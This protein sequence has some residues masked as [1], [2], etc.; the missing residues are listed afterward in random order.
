MQKTCEC[1]KLH[2]Y[3]SLKKSFLSYT[4]S[5]IPAFCACSRK[6][7]SSPRSRTSKGCPG[8]TPGSEGNFLP[9]SISLANA[10][11]V[12]CNSESTAASLACVSGQDGGTSTA[13][14]TG[15]TAAEVAA[16]T[17]GAALAWEEAAI[18]GVVV[19]AAFTAATGVGVVVA[20]GVGVV[21]AAVGAVLAADPG[22]EMVLMIRRLVVVGAG[23]AG[24]AL[25]SMSMESAP[26]WI[27]KQKDITGQQDGEEEYRPA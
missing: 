7:L 26:V 22:R 6:K 25:S 1:R 17:A 15:T 16:V 27:K 11:A 9:S 23:T 2:Q 5:A 14:T 4:V 3:I 20:T 18:T 13:A 21:V 8:T 19:A 24:V 12:F 10:R